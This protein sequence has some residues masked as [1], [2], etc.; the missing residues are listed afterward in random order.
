MRRLSKPLT[1]MKPHYEV[2]VVGSGYGGSIAASRLSRAG[3]GVCLLE[4]GKEFTPGTFPNNIKEAKKEMQF[5]KK[6]LQIGKQNGL[7]DFVL[8]DDISVFKGCGLG[9]TSLVNANV[10]IE[11][12]PRVFEDKIWPEEL[13]NDI[14]AINEGIERARK[15]L[16]PNPYPEGRDGY[17]ELAKT[18]A[19]RIS[20]KALKREFRM[21]DI[22]VNFSSGKNNVGVYQPRCKSCGDCVT[23][24]NLG[25]KNTTH[26]T[27]LPDSFN[28]GAEIFVETGVHHVEKVN[29][30]WKIFFTAYS[31]DRDKFDAPLMSI[32]ADNVILSAGALGSTEILMR[33]KK[34]GLEVSEM[35]GKRF[36]GN[37]DFLAFGYNN[38]MPINGIGRPNS[39]SGAEIDEIGPCITS[40]ID[41]RKES[42][43]EDGMTIEEGSIPSPIKDLMTPALFAFS[44]LTGRDTDRGFKDFIREKWREVTSFFRGPYWGSV[45]HTQVYL[46]M[47]NDD[48]MGSMHLG[49]SDE[50]VIEWKDV[51]RQKIFEK[52]SEQ[53]HEVSRALGGRYVRNPTWSK[54]MNF[55]LMTVHPLGGCVMGDTAKQGVVNH[56]GQVYN[57]T[58]GSKVYK[59][60]YVMDGAVFSRSVGTNPLLTISGISERNIALMI[61]DNHREVSYE[62]PQIPDDQ[63]DDLDLKPGV[64]FTETMTGY[65]LMGETDDYDKGYS[66]GKESDSPFEFTLTIQVDDIEDFII[67]KQH[68]AAMIGTMTAP[69]LSSKPLMAF[70]G[71]FNLFV[72]DA[73]REGCKKMLYKADLISEEEKAYRFEGYKEIF[74]DKG[75]DVWQD[76]TTLFIDVYEAEK[77]IGK[78]KLKIK[79]MDFKKQLTTMTALNTNTKAEGLKAQAKFG[80]FFA[81]NVYDSYC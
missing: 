64:Q 59:S 31:T 10:S 44:R 38:D 69:A 21:L 63:F 57:G 73:N 67:D 51:G 16:R 33:S 47:A 39:F 50:A 70:N 71:I 28:H 60:L 30:H 74:D 1:E 53:L 66:L 32:T 8:G 15:M 9:G 75:F 46:V 20:A 48:G 81:G 41:T 78:G 11:A 18:R 6:S 56:K 45:K 77:L 24:C 80:K 19:M 79:V 3:M 35:L 40:V 4:K 23:G 14:G 26:M 25:A 17:P 55:D 54:L 7:Y 12:D 72:D 13:R 5:N 61:E 34:Y 42:S 49:K 29:G 52:I 2:V 27:Y 62:F 37:G 43:L 58:E 65:F 76:T 22:N 36:S 68:E